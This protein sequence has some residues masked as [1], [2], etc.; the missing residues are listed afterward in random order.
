MFRKILIAVD[1]SMHSKGALAYVASV[2][3]QSPEVQFTLFNVQPMISQYL[4]EE[5][6]TDSK[7]DA[8]LRRV[9]DQQTV[10]SNALLGKACDQFVRMGVD[11]K[12]IKLV[13]QV[14]RQ[15]QAKDVIDYAHRHL[16]D[17]IVVGRRGLS[18][19][20]KA[21]MGS[22]SAKIMEHAASIPVWII[23]GDVRARKILVPIDVS[24]TSMQM[25]DY[26]GMILGG[27]SDVHLTL[28]H[29]DETP[30]ASH[31]T[32]EGYRMIMADA[33]AKTEQRWQQH[34]WTAT[35]KNLEEAGIHSSQ[36][37]QLTVPRT[38]RIA[39]MILEQVQSGDYDTVILGRRGSG[40]AFFF[41][42]V[43]HYV[44]E[45]LTDRAVWL[46]G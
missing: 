39:K 1:G 4:L 31:S 22:T 34:Y 23:D 15:G 13:S 36:I 45:R 32:A 5:A 10:D 46:I 38:G 44:I 9:I 35:Q 19:I 29:V 3:K 12:C 18:R 24:D 43:S 8:E 40:E 30:V 6:R 33:I 21:F 28:Y 11:L 27:Q 42:S 7:A 25:V 14:R 16:Y 20:Q 26:I 17:A 37:E 2:F 41:G